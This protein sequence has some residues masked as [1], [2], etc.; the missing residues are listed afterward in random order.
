MG[1]ES[2]DRTNSAPRE[3]GDGGERPEAQ[4]VEA[5]IVDEQRGAKSDQ[6]PVER[7]RRRP[8]PGAA[9]DRVRDVARAA[10][11]GV[12]PDERES[13]PDDAGRGH[14]GAPDGDPAAHPEQ[15]ERRESRRVDE[16]AAAVRAQAAP[17]DDDQ[18]GERD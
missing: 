4:N 2:T 10:R 8:T 3:H 9:A 12:D 14:R 7:W 6:D 1:A 5:R 11:K 13:D 17:A 16:E 15:R 18:R